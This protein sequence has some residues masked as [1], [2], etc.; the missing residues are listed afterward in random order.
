MHLQQVEAGLTRVDAEGV[1]EEP[2]GK[3]A[4][5][6]RPKAK[7]IDSK[8]AEHKGPGTGP[9]ARRALAHQAFKDGRSVDSPTL[10]RVQWARRASLS[11]SDGDFEEQDV[12]LKHEMRQL[13]GE[14]AVPPSQRP[15][16]AAPAPILAV[17][18]TALVAQLPAA[19]P[20]RRLLA[21][22]QPCTRVQPLPRR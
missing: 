8:H 9:A 11:D 21:S 19:P 13:L 12:R 14:T 10:L 1:G 7:S 2:S 20:K 18:Q 6:R 5:R 16:P 22:S 4:A 15:A 17:R 3:A